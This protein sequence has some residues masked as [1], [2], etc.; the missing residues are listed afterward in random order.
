MANRKDTLAIIPARDEAAFIGDVVR[1]ARKHV[2]R[3][4]VVD[5][6]S[7]DATAVEAAAAGAQVILRERSAGKGDAI[8]AGLHE[9]LTDLEWNHVL[10]LDGDGQHIPEEIPRLLDAASRTDAGLVI[11]DRMSAPAGMPWLRH[12]VNRFVSKQICG[13]CR[14]SIPDTQ[15]GFRLFRRDLVPLLLCETSGFDYET[16]VLILT[17][18]AGSK[19]ETVPVSCRYGAERSKINPLR[20]TV[21]YFLLM[22]RY[23]RSM[24]TEWETE[25]PAAI[26]S[27]S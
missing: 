12:T 2:A 18:R 3:V 10:F 22:N 9:A 25:S 23:R 27:E 21:R 4:I 19:I 17:A 16:E 14:N 15:C 8:K 26:G 20:D 11:G 5:D 24:R 1:R 7:T 13:L 6:G